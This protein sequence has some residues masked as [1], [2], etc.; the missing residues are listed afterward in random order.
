MKLS[1]R[2][3]ATAI[4][5]IL[6]VS[7]I[8]SV[9]AFA[10][11]ADLT[12]DHN[13][14]EAVNVL[15]QIG[16]INGYEEN[17]SFNFKP[18]N[19]VTRAEF[20]AMLLR[21][22]GM[23]NL[24]STS[25]DNPPFPD[26]VTPD[27]SWAIGNIRTAKE[28]GII[29]G[30]EEDGK[31]IFKPN[32]NVSYEEAVKMIVC[33]LGYGELGTEG[34]QWYSKYLKTATTLKFTDGAGGAIGVPA[35]R[36]TI[37]SMLYN[38]LEVNLAENNAVTEKTIL[39][40]DLGLTK[41]VGYI[42]SNPEISLFEPDSNLRDDEVQISVNGVP[43]TY[44]VENAAEYADMLGAQITFYYTVNRE[45][46]YKHLLMA[47]VDKSETI[48]I[49]AD[50]II[51]DINGTGIEYER[52]DGSERNLVANIDGNSVVVYN[53]K[54]YE[55]TAAQSTFVEFCK[56]E[57]L[58][59]IGKVKL[60]DRNGD[61]TYDVVFIDSYDA[62]IV[63]SK[64][65]SNYTIV[66]N[67][68]RQGMTGDG[69]KLVLAPKDTNFY[70]ISGN[71][72]SFSSISTGSVLCVK[73]SNAANGGSKLTSV[74]ICNNSITGTISA[75][76]SKTGYTISNKTYKSSLQ[77]PWKNVKAGASPVTTAPAHG[78]SGKFYL[79]C[80]GNILAFDK[81]QAANNQQYGY[82]IDV[83][84]KSDGFESFTQVLIVS[85]SNIKG[86][87]YTLSNKAELIK[88]SN[89]YEGADIVTQL[90]L[91]S[92][93]YTQLIKFSTNSKGEVSEIIASESVT[94]GQDIV[95]NKLYAYNPVVT[96]DT[97]KYKSSNL[98]SDDGKIYIGQALIIRV[99]AS[100]KV[101]EFKTWSTSNF[102]SDTDG[103]KVEFYDVTT[104]NSAKVVLVKDVPSTQTAVEDIKP[105]SPVIV[106]TESPIQENDS[107]ILE[108]YD[109]KSPNTKYVISNPDTESAKVLAVLEEGD[110][111]RIGG[112]SNDGY[113]IKPEYVIFG[114]EQTPER[115]AVGISYA[116]DKKYDEIAG[117]SS[118]TTIYGKAHQKPVEGDDR[119]M[120]DTGAADGIVEVLK[121]ELSNVQIFVYENGKFEPINDTF[122]QVYDSSY[123][124]YVTDGTGATP[125]E[126]FIH[127]VNS[128]IK[129]MIIVNS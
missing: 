33:A 83:D 111:V 110:V 42:A 29:N 48:E 101:S 123:M 87:V 127:Q 106:L 74:I 12:A 27:V 39:E 115:T 6:V 76:N 32:N 66:D 64:T 37:A 28:L 4:A 49:P 51:G 53:G 22:R 65:N 59:T 116:Y 26:V 105:D 40:N 19:N 99:P 11:F 60:L 54:L 63:S 119:F 73:K 75:T 126:V 118:Y 25:L 80:N 70:D 88:G 103:Y 84:E 112:N 125:S 89:T 3:M 23:G 120:I 44:K 72:S 8:V 68:L 15:S 117:Q 7:T 30:Y 57:E 77:A 47:H 5:V 10:D 24:G 34:A 20:T 114:V 92:G 108:G 94:T 45:S 36:A 128:T 13:A 67:I 1:K 14:Y 31:F 102:A 109:G 52:G 100:N 107:Y 17:G 122:E 2:V 35:T 50:K 56:Y 46:G 121:G 91:G 21:T 55:D 129:T 98:E 61:Q 93:D 85:K 96:D 104:T 79:D 16:V 9:P 113:I 124:S 90:D 95:S 69:N 58:P 86:N 38:C 97:Y 18:D 81:T 43:S 78:D 41:N 82:L 71:P 62:W